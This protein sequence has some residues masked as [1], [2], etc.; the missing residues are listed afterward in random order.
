MG[1]GRPREQG[2]GWGMVTTAGWSGSGFG[3]GFGRPLRSSSHAHAGACECG[4]AS[5]VRA[6]AQAR[7]QA[8]AQ[9]CVRGRVLHW[10][11]HRQFARVLH[12]Y[13]AH[14]RRK[15]DEGP[16]E[17]VRVRK[18]SYSPRRVDL[19]SCRMSE[20]RVLP[21]VWVAQRDG[22]GIGGRAPEALLVELPLLS[23]APEQQ[24]VRP[25]QRQHTALVTAL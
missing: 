6:C 15:Q 5:C 11:R 10:Y 8:R 2:E 18:A 19:A 1:G 21:S 7:A 3:F 22:A 12:W 20:H 9:A 17:C 13:C 25:H 16:F 4:R 14:I 24:R 23:Q